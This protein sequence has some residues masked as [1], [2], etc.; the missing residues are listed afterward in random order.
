MPAY[1]FDCSTCG[2]MPEINLPMTADNPP[3]PECGASLEKVIAPVLTLTYYSPAHPR[4]GR[5]MKG[6]PTG[7]TT[8]QIA[9]EERQ[10]AIRAAWESR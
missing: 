9:R 6:L 4:R 10:A 1:D 3:C 8:M 5:G 7:K 2:A